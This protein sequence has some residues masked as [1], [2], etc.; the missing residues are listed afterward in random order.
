M[1]SLGFTGNKFRVTIENCKIEI[2]QFQDCSQETIDEIK[3]LANQFDLFNASVENS[4][5]VMNRL[6]EISKEA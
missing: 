3:D 2:E 1:L 6:K 5:N 4:C